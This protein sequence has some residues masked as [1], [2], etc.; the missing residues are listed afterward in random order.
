MPLFTAPLLFPGVIVDAGAPLTKEN[1]PCPVEVEIDVADITEGIEEK[2]ISVKLPED[3]KLEAEDPTGR[4]L[5]ETVVEVVEE[6]TVL[7]GCNIVLEAKLEGTLDRGSAETNVDKADKAGAVDETVVLL[8]PGMA[9]MVTVVVTVTVESPVVP[10]SVWIEA[11]S[12]KVLLGGNVLGLDEE[13]G[14]AEAEEEA[15]FDIVV[16]EM[17]GAVNNVIFTWRL[18]TVVVVTVPPLSRSASPAT[19]VFVPA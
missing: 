2:G 13:A 9:V 12:G 6:T 5:L 17:A 18:L 19:V 4:M 11:G 1:P 15:E 16:D 14:N 3:D 10:M 7:A 8:G